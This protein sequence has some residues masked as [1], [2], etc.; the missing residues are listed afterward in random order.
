MFHLVDILSCF[1][2]ISTFS[3]KALTVV[4]SL[5]GIGTDDS[6][7]AQ[8]RWDILTGGGSSGTELEEDS[9]SESS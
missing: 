1:W 9:L 6:D 8:D 2:S 4:D 7:S 5:K 3:F